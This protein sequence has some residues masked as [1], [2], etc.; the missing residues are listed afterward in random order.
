[1]SPTVRALIACALVVAIPHAGHAEK[2]YGPGV[3]DT[4]I[5]IGQT[6]PYSGP[7]SAFGTM[8]RAETA[9]FE[10]INSKGGVNGRKIKLLSLDDGYSPPKTIEQTRKLVESDEVLLLFSSFGTP[11][12]T[13]A[14]KYLNAKKVPQLL[15]AATGMKWGD[16]RNF[17]WTMAFLPSQ[18]TGTTGYVRYL[19]KHRPEAKIG[20][21][22]QNDDFGKDY[23]RALKDLL[24]DRAASMIVAEVS[25]ESTDPSVDSQI[26]TLKGAGADTFFSFASPKF[27]AQSIRKAYDIDWKPLLFIPYSATSVSA[28]LQ[29]AGLQ[30]SVGVI[31]S[32]YVK[33]PTDPQWKTDAATKEWLTWIKS[34]Y[35]DGDV[36]E[37]YNVYAYTNAQLLIQVLKQCGD[38]LTRENV[39]KQ[40]ANLKNF[41][42]PML[43]PGVRINT[44]ATDYDPINQ[45]QLMRF[46]GKEWVRFGEVA[47]P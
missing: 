2:K 9:Y 44:S 16:P 24:G 4:E 15:I 19:L 18:K 25:Y 21:L 17:P 40:A 6:M 1:M 14:M 7:L 30:K 39:M 11:P 12:N 32:T 20:V 45:L 34:Y 47:G 8:G 3:T 35:P 33:D 46:D 28:V 5:K 43:L 36:A 22:Y 41:E 26:V 42:L 29:P 38:E 27:A 31:S 37:I 23:V 13:A 10:M